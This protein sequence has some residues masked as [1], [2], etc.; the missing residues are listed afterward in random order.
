M[1][2]K[3]HKQSQKRSPNTDEVQQWSFY[4]WNETK[5]NTEGESLR[6]CVERYGVGGWYSQEK[7]ML[8]ALVFLCREKTAGNAWLLGIKH[9]N[10]KQAA[11]KMYEND[12][13]CYRLSPHPSLGKHITCR[14][15]E[16]SFEKL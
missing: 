4:Y 1:G 8:A 12:P 13:C 11:A 16:S 7:D 15:G 9:L 14:L 6:Q 3:S 10:C 5:L 2:K